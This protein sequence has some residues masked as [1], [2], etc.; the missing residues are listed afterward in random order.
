MSAPA[1]LASGDLALVAGPRPYLA[2]VLWTDSFDALVQE[3]LGAGTVA[4]RLIPAGDILAT[5]GV[6]Y[7][8]RLQAVA[9][10]AT[11]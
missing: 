1:T 2:T 10:G 9:E 7:L 11:V 8:R 4:R 6:A 3:S 5:G